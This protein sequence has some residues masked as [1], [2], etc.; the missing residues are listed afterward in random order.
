MTTAPGGSLIYDT[1]V[2]VAV[3]PNLKR[4]TNFLLDRFFPNIVTADSE[5]VSIDVDVGKRRIAPFV[6]PLVEGKLVEQRRM[7]TNTFKPA[8]I[9]D[10][11][12]PDLRKPVRRMIGER[13]GGDMTGAER[14]MANLNA[15]MTDQ[16]DILT[17]RLEW[18]AASALSTGTV[19]ITGDGFP[20]VVVDFGRDPTL[21]IAKTGGAQWTLANVLAGTASPTGDIEAW[22]RQILKKSGAT[23]T[24]IIFTTSSWE[25]FIADPLLK[26]AI[27]YPKL[28]ESGNLI[29]PGA[30]IERGAVNK[31]RWGQYQLWIYNEWY[32]DSG[33]EG[34]QV[35]KE[36]PM[37]TDG[38]VIMAGPDMMGTRAFGQILDP[39]F[40]YAALPYAPKTWV[41]EDPAQ[42]Y[43]M[44]QSA[45]IVI[46]TR[47]NAALSASVCPAVFT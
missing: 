8:Y 39:A 20:T 5:F 22:Q 33:T 2:L 1:N 4:S 38:T 25:G 30:Q 43:L 29:N 34:G 15:E 42:R 35:D 19:T 10:K 18:M 47:V 26:G 28:G 9:K 36:Y 3:V 21:T 16:I 13:I 44:M 45:P 14:E 24:D 27:Y 32:V 6:S 40:N 46:P 12:A 11:R 7:Q 41:T 37:L 17:R 23:V 31:G